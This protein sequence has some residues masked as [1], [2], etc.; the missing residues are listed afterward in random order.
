MCAVGQ[1]N[2]AG[3]SIL[4][5]DFVENN[6][7]EENLKLS[8]RILAKTLDSS[9]PTPDRIELS[10]MRRDETTNRIIHTVLSNEEVYF[11]PTLLSVRD[12]NDVFALCC[13]GADLD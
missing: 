11:Y 7:I 1:N 12:L 2:Q 3:K 13:V 6:S 8:V 4:K 9:A 5:T 10:V